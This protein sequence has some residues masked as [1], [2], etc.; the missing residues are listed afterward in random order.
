MK[1]RQ[2]LG[3]SATAIT[4]LFLAVGFRLV[5]PTPVVAQSNSNLVISAATPLK[6]ALDEIMPLYQQT[7]PDVNI[8][9]NYGASGKLQEQIEQGMPSD[10]FI[11]TSKTQVDNMEE[12]GLLMPGTR[13][14]MVNNRLVLIVPK[15][16]SV[17]ITSFYTLTDP[18]VK[19]IAIGEPKSVPAGQ[20]GEQV[21]KKLGIFEKVKPKLVYVKNVSEV[22]ALVESGEADAGLSYS[23]DAKV[24]DKVKVAV[25]TEGKYYPPIIYPLAVL[26]SS[27]NVEAAKD[28]VKFLSSDKAKVVFKKYGFIVNVK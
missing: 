17:G 8:N 2:I 21:L 25:T 9:Y 6:D 3:L 26:K 13:G 16:N 15:K 10:I 12:R 5:T 23:T 7:K 20:Y 14:I 19:K 28:F 4:S 24:S 27:Q 1:R 22:L 18:K 11:S